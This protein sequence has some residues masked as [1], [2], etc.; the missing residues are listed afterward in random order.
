[1]IE[2]YD[3]ETWCSQ[4]IL[5]DKQQIGLVPTMGA[6]HE[7]HASLIERSV[8]ENQVTVV[9]VFVNPTQFDEIEDLNQYPETFQADR[10]VAS[11]LGVDFL[12][13]PKAEDMYPD[14]YN[15]RIIETALSLELEGVHRKGHFEGVLTVV[16]K[17]FNL[18]R[19]RYAYFGEKDFQQLE[20]V[21]G[22]VGAFFL[23]V[24][25]V[26]CP[27]IRE[28]D[29]LAVSSRNLRL[30]PSQRSIAGIFPKLLKSSSCDQEI[31]SK[32]EA[33]GFHVDYIKKIRGRR[34]GAVHLGSVRLIDNVPMT[35]VER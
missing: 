11:Q 28:E 35:E 29:G 10:R 7:G 1:M 15:H 31:V 17:L 12:L 24:E 27:T 2:I 26:G 20:L 14:D 30:T 8:K 22:I 34:Y 18:V 9:S 23:G 4:R 5:L 33:R 6:L 21:R 19:P 16:M 32:L 3:L 13:L 25:I